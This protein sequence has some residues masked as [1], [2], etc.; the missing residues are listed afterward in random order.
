MTANTDLRSGTRMSL[1][2][3]LALG[4]ADGKWEF[5]DGVIY[6]MSSGTR[7]HQ[8]LGLELCRRILDYIDSFEPPPADIF[9]HRRRPRR[10]GE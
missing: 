10:D 1:D 5:D 2:E 8:F 3:F 9:R 4:D 7:D 6:I